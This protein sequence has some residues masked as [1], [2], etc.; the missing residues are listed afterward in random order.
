MEIQADVI[1]IILLTVLIGIGIVVL[2]NIV[3][4]ADPLAEPKGIMVPVIWGIET[5]YNTCREN[6]GAKFAAEFTPYVVVLAVYIF[7][8]NVISLFGLPSPTSNLSV[9]LL[10]AFLTWL[11]IQ[12]VELKYAGIGGYL[13]SFIEPI[14]VLLPMNIF[15]KFSTMISMSLRLFGNILCGGIMMQMIYAFCQYLS[16][17]I[18][19]LLGNSGG[20]VNFIAPILTPVLHAYF[21]LFTG[22]IQTLVFV[23]LTVV[24]VG[25]DIP[26]EIK[27]EA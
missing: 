12:Y 27:K 23:T 17:T 7:T 22:F 13:H 16:N 10:L 15:G 26:E 24:L 1:T 3:K 8:S 2:S 25:N 4:K 9:T 18:A 21:D 14:A 11:I 5:I 20:T 6:C 19:G